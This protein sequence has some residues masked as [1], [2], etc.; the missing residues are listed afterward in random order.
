MSSNIRIIAVILVIVSVGESDSE[1]RKGDQAEFKVKEI[2]E[3]LN[4]ARRTI[5]DGEMRIIL[6]R[7]PRSS[8]SEEEARRAV[9]KKRKYWSK[10]L[11]NSKGE[12]RKNAE[13]AIKSLDSYF[14]FLTKGF[15]LYEERNIVF[16][17]DKE[18]SDGDLP[19]AY[20]VRIHS[21]DRRSY[22]YPPWFVESLYIKDTVVGYEH[23]AYLW[24]SFRENRGFVE[25]AHPTDTDIPYHLIGR[26]LHKVSRSQ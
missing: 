2:V 17:V 10:V 14:K 23:T 5:E 25:R 13:M 21:I 16:K 24:A 26:M 22:D 1:I 7:S 18:V 20:R 12:L 4:F 11:E 8:M 15:P 3:A 19:N 9:E 6:W